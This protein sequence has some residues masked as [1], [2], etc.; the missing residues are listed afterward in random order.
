MDLRIAHVSDLHLDESR[1][2]SVLEAAIERVK[3][4]HPDVVV[5]S[6]DIV[7]GWRPRHYG[8]TERIFRAL[9]VGKL[10][11]VVPDNHDEMRGGEVV[12][13]KHPYFRR[14]YREFTV[15]SPSFGE[16]LMYPIILEGDGLC[17]IALDS[18]EA[19]RSDGE[20]GLDQLLR[21]EELIREIEP[22]FIVL[23]M[24]HHVTPF[25]GLIDVSTVLDAGN[26]REFC[27]ANG[28]D[29]VL[30]GHKHIPRVD[31]F[32][33]KEGG[34]AVSHAGTLCP[35]VARYVPPAFNVVDVERGEVVVQV[36]EY[37]EGE[38]SEPKLMGRFR[39]EGEHLRPVELGYD[40]SKA[41]MRG[42]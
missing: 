42:Y 5:V 8:E 21:A 20:V 23:T 18:T 24:H 7:K 10:L 35:E 14:K 26:L 32:A 37:R 25:P 19:D 22:E 9:D 39:I 40:P 6:G 4:L 13:R 2:K 33:S 41:W 12:F 36:L 38:F 1:D 3:E 31:Y 15:K 28:V 16:L 27:V 34:C 11:A 29:L 17:V 30:V